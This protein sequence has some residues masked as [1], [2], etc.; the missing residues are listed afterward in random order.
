MCVRAC[1]CEC[2]GRGSRRGTCT[3]I[4]YVN[5]KHSLDP[6]KQ[7]CKSPQQ[8]YSIS[9]MCVLGHYIDVHVHVHV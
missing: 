8:L 3:Y 9:K 7:A 4:I 2:K 5:F 1:V 6:T